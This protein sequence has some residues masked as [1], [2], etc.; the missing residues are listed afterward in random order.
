M[1]RTPSDL[2]KAIT[3]SEE[4]TRQWQSLTPVARRDFGSWV[5]EARQKTTRASRV[6]RAIEELREGKRRPCCYAIFPLDLMGAIKKNPKAQNKWKALSPDEK[7]DYA[8]WVKAAT[9]SKELE[10]RVA[11]AT[12]QIA[13]GKKF[14]V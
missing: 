13:T 8:D 14:V 12:K 6:E 11:R 1:Q 9:S 7:R 5:E 2:K 3:A 10:K 4:A